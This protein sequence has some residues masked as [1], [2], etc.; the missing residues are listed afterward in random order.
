M[1]FLLIAKQ[2]PKN[3]EKIG[4]SKNLSETY[5]IKRL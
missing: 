4:D 1:K 5:K 2:I 3:T